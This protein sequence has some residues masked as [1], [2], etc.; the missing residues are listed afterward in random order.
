MKAEGGGCSSPRASVAGTLRPCQRT[1][2]LR[3]GPKRVG[4]AAGV[5]PGGCPCRCPQS[6]ARG[7]AGQRPGSVWAAAHA[8]ARGEERAAA[9]PP[10][11][12]AWEASASRACLPRAEPGGVRPRCAAL[13]RAGLVRG[14][15]SVSPLGTAAR[16]LHSHGRWPEV[17]LLQLPLFLLAG[18]GRP[19]RLRRGFH[20]GEVPG[21]VGLGAG[22][23]RACP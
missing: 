4:G 14:R 11:W 5:L 19:G 1:F 6:T 15:R 17:A 16:A 18:H 7:G 13:S 21:G 3:K 2:P 8:R 9:G 22:G 23:R 10:S 20:L 12:E